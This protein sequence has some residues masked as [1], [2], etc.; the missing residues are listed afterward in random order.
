MSS[1]IWSLLRSHI[2]MNHIVVHSTGSDLPHV[3]SNDIALAPVSIPPLEEQAEIVQRVEKLFKAIDSIAQDYQKSLQ[4]LD[5][6]DQATL[7]KAFRGELVPQDPND[8]PAAA[9][10]ER[11][12]TERQAEPQGKAVKSK[13]KRGGQQ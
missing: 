3:S 2:F 13:Q 11:I 1:F 10:L 9:L 5:R 6:L 7:A 12:R 8:E 4:L